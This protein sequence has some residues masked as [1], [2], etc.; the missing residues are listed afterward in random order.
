MPFTDLDRADRRDDISHLIAAVKADTAFSDRIDWD[1]FGLVGHSL[2]GYTVLALG[3]AWPEWKLPGVKAVLALS[4]YVQPFPARGTLASLAAPVM[5]QGGTW[6][7]G[8][9]PAIGRPAGAYDQP[10]APKYFVAFARAGH[11]AWTDLSRRAHGGID[12]YA[13]AFLDHYMRGEGAALPALPVTG[14][15]EVRAAPDQR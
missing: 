2:G 7:F 5:Y 4:P 8:I 14:M 11:L 6:D 9:T 3:G 1:R 12:A 10:P 13:V 15:A